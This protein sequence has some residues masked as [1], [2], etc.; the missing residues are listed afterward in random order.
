M[1]SWQRAALNGVL[2][3]LHEE[4]VGHNL[5][6]YDNS[7]SK[8][9]R[10]AKHAEAWTHDESEKMTGYKHNI[11]KQEAISEVCRKLFDTKQIVQGDKYSN[12]EMMTLAHSVVQDAVKV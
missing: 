1:D 4:K 3:P 9:H 10:R 6:W 7:I 8:L 2:H 12:F 5:K 11:R